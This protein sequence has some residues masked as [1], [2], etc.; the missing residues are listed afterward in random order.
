[1]H[2]FPS[3]ERSEAETV[4]YGSEER[5]PKKWLIVFLLVLAF[6]LVGAGVNAFQDF[7]QVVN[8][9]N[10][11]SGLSR[12]FFSSI[13]QVMNCLNSDGT[14]CGNGAPSTSAIKLYVA[15]TGNDSHVC[16]IG[17][18]CLTV[19]HTLSLVPYNPNRPYIINVADGTYAEGLQFT[20]Y[21]SMFGSTL[22]T[23]LGDTTTP[24]NVVFSGNVNCQPSDGGTYT[25]GVCVIGAYVSLQGMTVSPTATRGLLA[26]DDGHVQLNQFVASGTTTY[27]IEVSLGSTLSMSG[28]VTVSGFSSQGFKQNL[29][30]TVA[31]FGGTLSINAGSVGST[32]GLIVQGGSHFGL[33]DAGTTLSITNIGA[34]GAGIYLSANSTIDNQSGSGN[35]VSLTNTATPA[36]SIGIFAESMA[37]YQNISGGSLTLNHW[38]TCLEA[39]GNALIAAQNT[40]FSNCGTNTSASQQ[41]QIITF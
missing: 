12:M 16:S 33:H 30:S 7:Y 19:A 10:P 31:Q 1:M 4:N 39:D 32:V 9:S 2:L 28:N 3:R 26:I 24:A 25:T 27:G 29:G 23:I 18:P 38:T 14:S 6:V 5:Q 8:P 41:A 36:G 37:S 35:T 11:G 34:S 20:G 13:S 40:T 21:K 17:S 15:T 22:I